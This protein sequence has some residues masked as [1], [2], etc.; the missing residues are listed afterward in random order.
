MRKRAILLPLLV[1]AVMAAG[2]ICFDAI[3]V[4]HEQN[5][6]VMRVRQT[7][8]G[9]LESYRLAESE[10]AALFAALASMTDAA[11]PDGDGLRTYEVRLANRWGF[12]QQ[13]KI[14]FREDMSVYLQKNESAPMAHITDPAFFY[15]HEWFAHIYRDRDAPQFRIMRD[16]EPLAAF[17]KDY[18][19]HFLRHDGRWVSHRQP[20]TVEDTESVAVSATDHPIAVVVDKQ[21]DTS[22]LIIRN[23]DSGRIV[24]D[25][26][27]DPGHLPY[28][29]SNGLFDY[30]LALQWAGGDNPYRGE[31]VLKF[32]VIMDV[33]ETFRLSRRHLVQGEMLEVVACYVTDADAV[34]MEQSISKNFQWYIHDQ[35]LRGYIPT[36]YQTEPGVYE[37]RYGN[38]ESGVEYR[39]EIEVT[40]YDY[41]IQ[42]LYISNQIAKETR[43]EAAYAEFAQYFTPVRKQ[44][45]PFRYYTEPFVI[46]VKGRLT[47]EFGQ[48]RYVNDAPTSSRH[49]GLDIAAPRG[50]EIVAAN[51]GKVVLSMPLILTGETVVID[52][53]EG[54]FSV[55]YHMEERFAEEGQIVERGQPIATVGSTGFSTGPHL[56]FTMSYYTTN[57]DPGFLL[58]GQPI[59]LANF[60]EFLE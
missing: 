31:A 36:N 11:P 4:I 22:R 45:E 56:H 48:T 57:I 32:A 18:N 3:T 29:S 54:L 2:M 8:D 26:K 30:E 50:T 58:V 15:H 37:I 47:T 51:R 49:S 16:E 21:P 28:P 19:W 59:T 38:R 41:R 5:I 6:R 12:S 46:P 20:G 34:F 23:R 39:E 13:Y 42:K 33:P 10:K 43:N 1:L 24:V 35:M 7:Q 14:T 53:G 25:Q 40:P 9:R 52:H 55:Y 44:S 27:V 60:R 17:S